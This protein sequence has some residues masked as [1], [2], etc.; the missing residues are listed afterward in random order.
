MTR[1][2]VARGAGYMVRIFIREQAPS[3]KQQAAK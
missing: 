1:Q 3:R 2:Q